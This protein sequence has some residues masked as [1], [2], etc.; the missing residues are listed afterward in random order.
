[1][2]TLPKTGPALSDPKQNLILAA[3]PAADY[4]RMLPDLHLV[5]LPRG[6]LMIEAGD[7]VDSLHFPVSGIVS[8]I[9]ELEDGSS[10]ETAL[11]GNEGLVGISIYMGGDSL[12]SSTEVQV[13]GDA[14][15]LSRA[16]MKREFALGGKL[17]H[18]ALLYA[19][20]LLCQTSQA[21]LC[22][23]HHSVEQ[24]FCRWLLAS[25]DRLEA[26]GMLITQAQLSH[27]LGA[28][29][30][31]VTK[32]ARRLEKEGLIENGRGSITLIDR[33]E[34]EA[35]VCECYETVRSESLRLMPRPKA[36]R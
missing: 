10:S 2:A 23:Q 3:L 34:M 4:E 26:P 22:N 33:P 31:T 12:P 24:K 28:R 35:R 36:S 6:L 19:Q 5:S 14:Y 20:V 32:T 15:R 16:V 27:L 29:R 17:Q 25:M 21:A 13:K 8:L 1:M 11:V 7:H 18:L 30:E 9:Y